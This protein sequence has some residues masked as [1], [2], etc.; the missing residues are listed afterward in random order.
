[1]R[2]HLFLIFLLCKETFV[3]EISCDKN[4]FKKSF[5]LSRPAVH[6]HRFGIEVTL[7]ELEHLIRAYKLR[8]FEMEMENC[9]MLKRRRV[10]EKYLLAYQGATSFLKDF[11]TTRY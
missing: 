2:K 1:M 6:F 10:F 11:H 8:Q 3:S 5:D 4:V 9:K 7:S